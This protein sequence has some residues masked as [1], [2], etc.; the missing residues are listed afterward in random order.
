MKKGDNHSFPEIVRNYEQ[1]G[2]VSS[3]VGKD[4]SLYYHLHIPGWYNGKAG[5]FEF[6]KDSKGIITHRLFRPIKK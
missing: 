6:I 1:F 4:G 2:T 5:Q 3:Q